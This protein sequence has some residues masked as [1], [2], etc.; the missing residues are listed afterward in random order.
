[1]NANESSAI[2]RC[3]EC[4]RLYAADPPRVLCLECATAHERRLDLVGKAVDGNQRTT[5]EISRQTGLTYDEV[6]KALRELPVLSR[7]VDTA[8]VCEMC[9]RRPPIEGT[10]YC[11][12]CQI[13]ALHEL[14][15]A[16]DESFERAEDE[17][18]EEAPPRPPTVG[19]LL[20]S[21][22][23]RT[24]T[25]RINPVGAQKIKPNRP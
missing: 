17:E 16:A 10:L 14:R 6:R 18:Y 25:A 3:A 5:E 15:Q 9:R 22:R 1:M 21:K 20:E 11:L 24:T 13:E 19:Q 12:Y 4:G 23:A 2:R 7:Y 8:P